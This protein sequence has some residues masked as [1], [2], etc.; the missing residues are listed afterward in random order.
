MNTKLKKYSDI[1]NLIV[2]KL[3]VSIIDLKKSDNV[4]PED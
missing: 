3:L 1:P 4:N 2:W